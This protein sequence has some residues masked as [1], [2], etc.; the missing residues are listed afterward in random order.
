M[1]KSLLLLGLVALLISA[2]TI[3][4]P[5]S[6]NATAVNGSGTVTTEERTVSGF[7][8]VV[9]KSIGNVVITHGDTESLTIKADDNILPYITTEVVDGR[10]EIGSKPNINLVPS[11]SIDYILTVKSLSA[12]TLSGFGNINADSLDGTNL[13]VKLTGSGDININELSGDTFALDLTGFGN[14]DLAKV[15]ATNTTL[16]LTGSGDIGIPALTAT[17]LALTISGFGNATLAGTTD[18]Q[19]VSLTGSGDYRGGDLQS[20][21]GKVTISGFGNATAW[22]TDTIDITI[23][24]SGNVEYYG[25]PVVNT[26]LTG[27]GKINSLGE[28]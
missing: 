18:N 8:E 5:Y 28:H 20:K 23:T 14:V 10:L 27:M 3:N 4:V 6:I 24:G 15:S 2:C 17:K 9:L 11:H 25:S 26:T 1:K 7:N 22:T 13:A 19:V 12:I 16:N 21:T